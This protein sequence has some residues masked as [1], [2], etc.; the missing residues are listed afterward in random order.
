M[1]MYVNMIFSDCK[2]RLIKINNVQK[3]IRIFIGFILNSCGY[4][5]LNKRYVKV[6]YILL[7]DIESQ[8]IYL[9]IID[10]YFFVT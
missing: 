6:Q 1:V 10:L 4:S 7:I 2:I 5:F 3:S 9:F 8:K